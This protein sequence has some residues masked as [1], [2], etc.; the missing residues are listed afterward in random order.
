MHTTKL[1]S[2]PDAFFF[3]VYIKLLIHV[4]SLLKYLFVRSDEHDQSHQDMFL[5]AKNVLFCFA[6]YSK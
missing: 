2:M 1:M 3:L 6:L 4:H 5:A